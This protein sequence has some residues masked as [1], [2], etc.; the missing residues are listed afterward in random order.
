MVILVYIDDCPLI[1][2]HD[3]MSTLKHVLSDCFKVKDLGPIASILGIEVI[4]DKMAGYLC[5]CQ[6][7]HILSAL[8]TFNMNDCL[9]AWTPY[10]P[11]YS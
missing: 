9:P 1:T 4:H 11:D 8:N 10:L 3:N 6:Q 5:L 2:H 7:G